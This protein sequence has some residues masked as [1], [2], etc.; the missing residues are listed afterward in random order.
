MD[1]DK[2]DWEKKLK[3]FFLDDK[4]KTEDQNR[5]DF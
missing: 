4:Y 5:N 3:N 1:F 2:K